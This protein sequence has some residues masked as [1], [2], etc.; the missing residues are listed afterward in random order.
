ME[1]RDSRLFILKYFGCFLS[2]LIIKSLSFCFCF[3]AFFFLEF[4][5][6]FMVNMENN[7]GKIEGIDFSSFEL[8]KIFKDLMLRK[9]GK[10][11]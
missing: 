11:M 9:R 10:N 1:H 6:T 3:V 5:F 8:F 4:P 7:I 2:F